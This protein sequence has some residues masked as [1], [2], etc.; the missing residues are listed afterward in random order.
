[1]K[2]VLLILIAVTTLSACMHID[3]Q[4]LDE[5]KAMQKAIMIH[6]DLKENQVGLTLTGKPIAILTVKKIHD[7][8]KANTYLTV[9]LVNTRFNDSSDAVKGALADSIGYI[10]KQCA[11]T[12]VFTRGNVSFIKRNDYGIAH[13]SIATG[14]PMH[15]Q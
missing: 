2:H 12:M 5:M 14:F 10:C 1:M 7:T 3:R 8:S 11:H 9:N 6:Y 4:Q 13:A 15:L